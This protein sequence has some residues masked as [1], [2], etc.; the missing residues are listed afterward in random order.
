MSGAFRS[1]SKKNSRYSFAGDARHG[2]GSSPGQGGQGFNRKWIQLVICFTVLGLVLVIKSFFPH[3]AKGLQSVFSQNLGS[4]LDYKTAFSNI[5]RAVSHGGDI[6]AIWDVISQELFASQKAIPITA[7]TPEQA[8]ATPSPPSSPDRPAYIPPF[9]SPLE[10]QPQSTLHPSPTTQILSEWD[11]SLFSQPE[12]DD[13]DPVPFG[14]TRPDN[15]DYGVY[16]ID[17]PY[18]APLRGPWTSYFGYRNHP[19]LGD[20]RFHYGVDIAANTGTPIAAFADGVV[21]AVG[22]SNVNGLYLMIQ[23]TGG[24][25]TLYAHCSKIP[26]KKGQ[27]VSMGDTIALVGQTGQATGPHLHF[28]VRRAGVVI[29][30]EQYLDEPL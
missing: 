17:F 8:S 19:I 20:T 27:K 24:F 30:P 11:T 22:E 3:S 23:H 15:V 18:R 29:N 10:P 16:P 14:Y 26:V 25:L 2:D 7:Q 28:E 9:S 4:G 12:E 6:A 13:T 1:T 5:G 21:D